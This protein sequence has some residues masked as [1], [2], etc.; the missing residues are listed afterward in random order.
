[1]KLINNIHTEQTVIGKEKLTRN[2]RRVYN[3]LE[4][5]INKR[6]RTDSFNIG[7]IGSWGSDMKS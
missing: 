6:K 2:Q 1:M 7:L 3:Q 4:N 5:L